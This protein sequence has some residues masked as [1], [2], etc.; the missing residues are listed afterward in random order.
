MYI[1]F[2]SNGI[3]PGAD[4]FHPERSTWEEVR[5]LPLSYFLV[6]PLL[7]FPFSPCV[8]AMLE[9]VFNLLSS[10]AAMFAGFLSDER[11]VD[12]PKPIPDASGR[13]RGC[14]FE[15][16]RFCYRTWSC[17]PPK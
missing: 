12:K 10:W 5:D 3:L 14:N 7:N 11:R 4:A 16:R 9:G 8:N 15:L 13:G 1:V 17:G 6:A 2:F